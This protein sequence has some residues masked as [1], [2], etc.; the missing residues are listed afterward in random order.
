MLAARDDLARQAEAASWWITPAVWLFLQRIYSQNGFFNHHPEWQ[1]YKNHICMSS[2]KCEYRNRTSAGPRAE[3][4]ATPW[5]RQTRGDLIRGGSRG[6]QQ[7]R[8][9]I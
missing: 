3:P 2:N 5:D 7:D 1:F 6:P 8:D 4:G 9:G